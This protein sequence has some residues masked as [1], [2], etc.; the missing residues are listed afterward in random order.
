MRNG[1]GVTGGARRNAERQL[2]RRS[3]V[4]DGS[5]QQTLPTF[6]EM[7]GCVLSNRRDSARLLD[8]SV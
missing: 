4:D 6:A 5:R 8:Y 7:T 2:Q 3:H 1:Y